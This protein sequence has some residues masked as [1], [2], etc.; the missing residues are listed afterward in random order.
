MC[1]SKATHSTIKV[2]TLNLKIVS[3]AKMR[4]NKVE[5]SKATVPYCMTYDTKVPFC[6]PSFSSIKII[7][8]RFHIVTNKGEPGIGYEMIIG[9]DLM[10]QLGLLE[11]NK[12]QLLQWDGTNIPMKEQSGLLGN[13]I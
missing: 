1:N 6:M 11:K 3:K 10:V 2:D 5:Y 12:C 8:H 7:F 13:Q 9:N 4:S